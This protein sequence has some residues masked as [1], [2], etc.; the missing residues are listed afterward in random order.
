VE[1][2][3]AIYVRTP[4]GTD[5]DWVPM[6]E[7]VYHKLGTDRTVLRGMPQFWLVARALYQSDALNSALAEVSAIQAKIAYVREH[8][9]G[10]M[11]GQITDFVGGTLDG[12]GAKRTPY[13]DRYRRTGIQEEGTTVD[14]SA[15]MKFTAGPAS[16]GVPAFVQALQSRLRQVCARFGYPEFFT[17]DASNNNYA[18]SLTAG[19]PAEKAFKRKQHKYAAFQAAV[20]RRACEYAVAD[21]RLSAADL[22]AVEIK[23]K[24]SNVTIANKLEEAQVQ[25]IRIQNK[26]LSPQTAMVENGHDPKVEMANIK[27][28][29]D[30]FGM[31]AMGMGGGG[32]GGGFDGGFDGEQLLEP[33]GESYTQDEYQLLTE[34]DRS[35]FVR[36]TITNSRGRKQVVWVRAMGDERDAGTQTRQQVAD[37]RT[38]VAMAVADPNS[39]NPEQ[40][41]ALA[42]HLETVPRD[43]IRNLLKQVGEKVGG[44]KVE[45]A[46][47]LVEKVRAGRTAAVGDALARGDTPQPNPR[48]PAVVVDNPA[49][50]GN[51]TTV[52]RAE[53]RQSPRRAHRRIQGSEMNDVLLTAYLTA[54]ADGDTDTARGVADLAGDDAAVSVLLADGGYSESYTPDEHA[55][56]SEAARVGLVLK[57]VGTHPRTGK[58][59]MR[60]VRATPKADPKQQKAAQ[61]A[62]AMDAAREIVQR[63]IRTPKDARD[64]AAHLKLL[65][66]KEIDTL[67][68]EHGLKMKGRLKQDKVDTLVAYAQGRGSID[69]VRAKPE[70]VAP[71]AEPKV[72]PTPTPTQTPAVTT[73]PPAPKQ[74]PTPAD[75]LPTVPADAATA[76]QKYETEGKAI[77]NDQAVRQAIVDSADHLSQFVEYQHELYPMPRMYREV[78]KRVPG[79]TVSQFQAAMWQAS[80]GR[81]VDLH[82]VN[83]VRNYPDAEKQGSI[84]TSDRLYQFVRLPQNATA[85]TLKPKD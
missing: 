58:P 27:A 63:G 12:T 25:Q 15:G 9:P 68:A 23:V 61:K 20:Y 85:D 10:I 11:P 28:F 24:A 83:E 78:S 67:K 52:Q 14:M 5:G 53:D 21:G 19:G 72:Q 59:I 75:T 7:M 55:L 42:A 45:L 43:E 30:Q 79:L 77:L 29:D 71:K 4:D 70:P 80:V 1:S 35:R 41:R 2:K 18:S 33:T 34:A 37:A 38:L 49:S 48:I 73:P 26:T 57:Q 16:T 17:G 66:A 32:G 76:P 60:Y 13:G 50:V 64:M 69:T 39:L 74:A 3:E 62:A 44:Q 82:A 51:T 56:L 81:A 65:T 22:A 6:T 8:A 31:G 36:K 47:R 46:N 54:L 84:K 40:F